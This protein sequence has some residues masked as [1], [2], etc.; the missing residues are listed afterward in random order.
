MV[1]R[2]NAGRGVVEKR[3]AVRKALLEHDKDGR[4]P[5]RKDILSC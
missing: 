5:V 3:R 4:T 2:A 1:I